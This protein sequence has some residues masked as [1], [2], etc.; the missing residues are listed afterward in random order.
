VKALAAL[1]ALLLPGVLPAQ[2]LRTITGTR[3]LAD[4]PELNVNVEFAAGRLIVTRDERG[5]LYRVKVT[6]DEDRFEPRLD[7]SPGQNQLAVGVNG[8]KGLKGENRDLK[9]QALELALSPTVPLTF[10]MAFGAGYAEVDLGGL[11]LV[12][13]E[14]KTGASQATVRFSEPNRGRCEKL[15]FHVGAAEFRAEQLGNA[16]CRDIS[17]LGGATD[18]VLDL[19]G[20][21]GKMPQANVDVGVGI[22]DLTLHLPRDIGIEVEIKRFLAT[23]DRSG[24]T[25][26]GDRYYTANFDG[27]ATKLFLDVNAVMGSVNIVWR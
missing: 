17:F 25:K 1:A 11:N 26:R 2:A 22:A 20:D 9:G 21:W 5:A 4:Q 8:L 6:Y 24:L 16:Q 10:D 12:R 3:Q 14:I 13:A 27:A 18:L 19:T 7:F 15:S 23:F